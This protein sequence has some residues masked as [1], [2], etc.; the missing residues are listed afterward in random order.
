[1]KDQ[2]SVLVLTTSFPLYE[3]I[4]VGVHVLEKCRH[5]VKKGIKIKVIAPHHQG[6]KKY[7]KMDGVDIYRFQY[8]WPSKY[9]KLAYGAGIPTNLRSGWYARFQF[10]FFLFFFLLKAMKRAP[11]SD[12]VHCHWSIAG[13]VGVL[14]CKVFNKKLVFMM[15]GAEVFVLGK[16]PLLRFVLK[17]VDYLICNSTFT[18]EQTLRV[19]PTKKQKV[20]SPGVDVTRFFPQKR[21]SNLRSEIGLSETDIFVLSIGKFI[22]RKGFGYLIRAFDI[23]V[24]RCGETGIHLRIGGRGPLKPAYDKL[25]RQYKLESYIG[26]LGYVRDETIPSYYTEADIF[27]LPSIVDDRGDTEGLG[28]VFLE[29]NA[30]GTPVI[31]SA[32]GG[33][34][35]VIEDGY[36][37]FQVQP[38]NPEE[39]A[40]RIL[41]L[42]SA[43]ELRRRMGENGRKRVVQKFNWA[44]IANEIN[45]VYNNL[46]GE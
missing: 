38:K 28:V 11:G 37:G 32:V 25:I 9:Q 3:G 42:A 31:G 17:R 8:V 35:D 33:I 12:I 4:A 36:N 39:L 43:N 30:C 6:A 26:F 24:N 22:P 5:L 15:H 14:V 1:M 7:E 41:Q 40:D 20:I 44:T 34:V 29:A 10:P 45:I 13:I 18:E 2:K 23:I 21:I 16:N 27:V 19:Y 46:V